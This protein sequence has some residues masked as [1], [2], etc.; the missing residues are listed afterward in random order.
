MSQRI[1]MPGEIETLGS[2][3]IPELLLPDPAA[4]FQSRS[5]RLSALAPGHPMQ[6][7]LQLF[8]QVAAIQQQ[9]LQDPRLA[10]VPLPSEQQIAQA[11]EFLMPPLAVAT[12]SRDPL[13][14][15]LARELAGQLHTRAGA[16]LPEAAQLLLKKNRRSARCLA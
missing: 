13:W 11:K 9:L 4:V 8:S 2:S 10:A 1:L 12:W 7:Y 14:Q 6:G 16:E 3:T 5:K 15:T